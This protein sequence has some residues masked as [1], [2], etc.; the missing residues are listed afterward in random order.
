MGIGPPKGHDRE[1]IAALVSFEGC[2]GNVLYLHS[3]MEIANSQVYFS[4]VLGLMQLIPKY[5]TSLISPI[6]SIGCFPF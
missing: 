4:E 1:L 3:N 2:H 5:C 6:S